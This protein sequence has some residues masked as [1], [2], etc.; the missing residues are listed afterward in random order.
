MHQ[1]LNHWIL[2]QW[3]GAIRMSP[4]SWWQQVIHMTPVHQ[5]TSCEV[6]NCMIVRNKSIIKMFN[7]V[8]SCGNVYPLL[9]S[10]I[11]I[12]WHVYNCFGLFSL[13][14]VLVDYCTVFIS[15]LNS[16]SG[17]THWWASEVMQNFSKSVPMKKKLVYILDGL[18]VRQF[19]ANSHFWVNY[20]FKLT[21]CERG[22]GQDLQFEKERICF[23]IVTRA[24]K[25]RHVWAYRSVSI[26]LTNTPI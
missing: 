17:G 18:K 4:N 25:E 16:H 22:V 6:K 14:N 13:V 19:S 2:L 23:L 10:Q 26:P 21:N 12:H 9:S 5:L 7:N 20:S 1:L 15:H 8:S 24:E 11:K 3:M